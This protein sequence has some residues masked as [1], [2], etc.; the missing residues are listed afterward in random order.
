MFRSRIVVP[1]V[2]F[3]MAVKLV[4]HALGPRLPTLGL[5]HLGGLTLFHLFL[6]GGDVMVVTLAG[7]L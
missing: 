4:V 3:R 2:L 1:L 6:A 7:V 5:L